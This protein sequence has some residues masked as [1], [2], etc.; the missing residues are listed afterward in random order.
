MAMGITAASVSV[1]TGIT[2]ASHATCS[3]IAITPESTP[4]EIA[5]AGSVHDVTGGFPNESA[6]LVVESFALDPSTAPSP[7]PSTGSS[8]CGSIA[9]VSRDAGSARAARWSA[10]SAS[11]ARSIAGS[12]VQGSDNP[13]ADTP[14]ASRQG[15]DNPRAARQGSDNPGADT[16][17]HPGTGQKTHRMPGQGQITRELPGR[18]HYLQYKGQ[19]FLGHLSR[20]G[21]ENPQDARQGADNLRAS[22]DE[23][24]N[25]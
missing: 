20:L 14:L 22:R 16:R 15:S 4:V 3:N 11:A 17:E 23:S 2:A 8:T 18:K 9:L 25:P 6:A 5:S 1:E 13:G 19:K 21:L 24:D 7:R 12:A 10:E